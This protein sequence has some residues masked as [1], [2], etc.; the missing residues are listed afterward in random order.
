MRARRIRN[1]VEHSGELYHVHQSLLQ[2]A[3]TKAPLCGDCSNALNGARV[4][5]L[6]IAN[7]RDFGRLDEMHSAI[8]GE[9]TLAETLVC[10]P[11]I[12]LMEVVK[13]VGSVDARGG[14]TTSR[15]H[16]ITFAHNGKEKLDAYCATLPRRN[17]D[18][19][20]NV[21]FVGEKRHWLALCGKG[22]MRNRFLEF[23]S[24]V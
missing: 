23:N 14:A 2:E 18:G 19:R 7:D 1:V 6:S 16:L 21:M 24:Q 20:L 12:R 15:G 5:E 11:V 17:L 13:F 9:L 10:S 4:P 22:A 3:G 8:G